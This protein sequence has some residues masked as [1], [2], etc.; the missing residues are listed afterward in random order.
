MEPERGSDAP[1]FLYK[2]LGWTFC[3]PHPFVNHYRLNMAK[4]LVT[5]ATGFIGNHVVNV[6]LE[7]KHQVIASSATPDKATAFSWYHQVTYRPLRLE[8]YDSSVNYFDYF[9]RPDLAIH[10]SWE[11]LP[12]YTQPFHLHENLPRHQH[13]LDNL[14]RHGLK[15]LSVSGTCFEYGMQSGCLNEDMKTAPDNAYAIAKDNLRKHLEI[16]CAANGT[17]LKW[18]RLFY[19]YGMGQHPKSLISQLDAALENNDTVFN[20]SGGEQIRD[21]LPIKEVAAY[22]SS[23]A[24]QHSENGIINC[25][26]GQPVSVKD[27]VLQYLKTKQRSIKLNLGY[28]PYASYE[29]MEFWGDNTKLKRILN[30]YK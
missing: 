13:F 19:M 3:Y 10:L 27:F 20:M 12:N 6:L 2:R 8:A 28:Y 18:I 22:I 16:Q 21:F 14:L 15:D 9:E 29:P 5:G 4:V 23:I 7:R 24:C 11:N 17:L 30:S 1:A 25:C 26:S